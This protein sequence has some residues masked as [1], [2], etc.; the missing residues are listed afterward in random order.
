M[1]HTVVI[2]GM[3]CMHCEATVKK[4]LENIEGIESAEVSHEKGTA[5]I[6]TTCDVD[7]EVIK[8]AVEDKDYKFV[9]MD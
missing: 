1:K 9:S 3:M 5:V 2:E 8:K 4:A 6:T 7:P